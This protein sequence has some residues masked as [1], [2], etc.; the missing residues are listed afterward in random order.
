M[1]AP[2]FGAGTPEA[3]WRPWLAEQR[4]VPL[5]FQGDGQ[6]DFQGIGRAVVVAP[7]PDDEIL[8]VGGTMALLRAA[9]LAVEVIALTDG[10]ASHPGSGVLAPEALAMRRPGETK[11]ALARLGLGDV[12]VRRLGLPDGRLAAHEATMTKALEARLG[13]QVACFATWE[14]DGH[15]DHEAAGRAARAACRIRGARLFSYPVWA[16]HWAA[17]G[18]GRLP[19]ARARRTALSPPLVERKARAIAAFRTQ[20]EPLGPAA[21]D[22]AILPPGVCDRFRRNH[23]IVFAQ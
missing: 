10:E 16:W 8:G 2:I 11:E 4:W 9:G 7:H 21:A 14:G 23:E 18:D 20:V 22:A 1:T 6:G 17:P 19:W 13:P 5:D 3:Q 15:P 12:A